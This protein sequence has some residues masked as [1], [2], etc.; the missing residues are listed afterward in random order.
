MPEMKKMGLIKVVNHHDGSCQLTHSWK[1]DLFITVREGKAE[2]DCDYL[3]LSLH[4]RM[5]S[6]AAQSIGNQYF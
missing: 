3:Q 6:A 5:K 2:I 1:Q 4:S